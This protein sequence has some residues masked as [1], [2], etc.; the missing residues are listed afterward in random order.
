MNFP[1]SVPSPVD[2]WDSSCTEQLSNKQFYYI[3]NK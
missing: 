2:H 1:H 3:A